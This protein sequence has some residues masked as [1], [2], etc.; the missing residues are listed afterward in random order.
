MQVAALG[1]TKLTLP[2]EA[3]EAVEILGLRE[4]QTP[5][6]VAVV[7]LVLQRLAQAAPVSSS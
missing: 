3:L 7:A 4:L 6:V 5:E 1:Q 2:Q